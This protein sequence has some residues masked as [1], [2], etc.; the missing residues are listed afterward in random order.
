MRQVLRMKRLA[1]TNISNTCTR[2]NVETIVCEHVRSLS[3]E[4]T[5]L[6]F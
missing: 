6:A 5:V 4:N 2:I 3:Y 1:G